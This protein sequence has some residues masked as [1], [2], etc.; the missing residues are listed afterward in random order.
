[1]AGTEGKSLYKNRLQV[2]AVL[3]VIRTDGGTR[4]VFHARLSVTRGQRMSYEAK[5]HL[6]AGL[7]MVEPGTV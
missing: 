3:K 5:L 1:M 2:R 7:S 4:V 6:A